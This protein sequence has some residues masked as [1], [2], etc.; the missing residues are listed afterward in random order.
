[1]EIFFFKSNSL[2]ADDK[3]KLKVQKFHSSKLSSFPVIKNT[4]TGVE[5]RRGS[6]PFALIITFVFTHKF[7]I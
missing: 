3:T 7:P 6:V 2:K 4:V 5:G 1:M